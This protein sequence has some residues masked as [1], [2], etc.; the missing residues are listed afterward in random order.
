MKGEE[1]SLPQRYE[2]AVRYHNE[3]ILLNSRVYME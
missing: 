1:G 2:P 3:I